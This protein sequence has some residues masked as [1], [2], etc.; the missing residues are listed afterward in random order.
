MYTYTTCSA[1]YFTFLILYLCLLY[2]FARKRRVETN[3][4]LFPCTPFMEITKCQYPWDTRKNQIFQI[5][6]TQMI[7]STQNHNY[8]ENISPVLIVEDT[9]WWTVQVMWL[10]SWFLVSLSASVPGGLHPG[11]A[12][13]HLYR[14]HCPLLLRVCQLHGL[15]IHAAA[16]RPPGHTPSHV[17]EHHLLAPHSKCAVTPL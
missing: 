12:G 7:P 1:F 13:Q 15:S 16:C 14:L 3:A 10:M 8:D 5:G 4:I 9:I 17:D 6:V 2:C 11:G